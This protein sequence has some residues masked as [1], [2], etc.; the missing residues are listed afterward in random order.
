MSS[1][2]TLLRRIRSG[3]HDAAWNLANFQAPETMTIASLQF[4]EGGPIELVHAARRIG[5]EDLSPELHWSAPPEGTAELLLVV[6]D[7][8]VPMPKPFVHCIARIDLNRLHPPT[9]RLPAGALSVRSPAPGVAVL[10]STVGRGY[11]GPGPIKG[12]GPHHYTFQLFAL[13]RPFV[14]GEAGTARL[15]R[16]RPRAVLGALSVPVLARGRLTGVFER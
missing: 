12:H 11:R 5:G 3:D 4:D 8:D 15:E 2:G 14:T 1:F 9:T 10:R 16:A 6:E 7:V 13:A